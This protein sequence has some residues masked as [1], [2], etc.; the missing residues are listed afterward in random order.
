[1]LAATAAAPTVP[2]AA[3]AA[4]AAA[5][6][7]VMV[8]ADDD[9]DLSGSPLDAS[10]EDPLQRAFAAYVVSAALSLALLY[11]SRLKPTLMPHHKQVSQRITD[12]DARKFFGDAFMAAAAAAAPA[13]AVPPAAAAAVPLNE[14]RLELVER[15]KRLRRD[16]RYLSMAP[17]MAPLWHP[18]WLPLWLLCGTL[19]G[20]SVAH[21]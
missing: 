3:A 18:L 2:P 1:M 14:R 5:D 17:S 9:D 20:S 8:M 10:L 21:T 13:A 7:V 16:E 19:Y 6:D 12:P 11:G 15:R 4:A